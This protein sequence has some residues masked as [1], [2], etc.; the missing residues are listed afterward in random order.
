[1]QAAFASAVTAFAVIALCQGGHEPHEEA[2][3]V[4]QAEAQ[5]A[6]M[7]PDG[8]TRGLGEEVLSARVDSQEV[9][10]T[11]A[12]SITVDVPKLPLAGQRRPPCPRS[13]EVVINGGCW[14]HE[15]DIEPPCGDYYEWRGECYLPVM[16]RT[17]VPTTQKPQ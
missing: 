13:A 8:G 7:A 1:L 4:A 2:P 10:V 6:E 17:R 12:S 5:D 14:K 3:E 15:A 9:P 11:S 16:G